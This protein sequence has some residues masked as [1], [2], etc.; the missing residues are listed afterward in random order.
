MA[1]MDKL[2]AVFFIINPINRWD[3]MIEEVI[4]VVF[5]MTKH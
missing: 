2:N 1:T 5:T 3:L 4:I